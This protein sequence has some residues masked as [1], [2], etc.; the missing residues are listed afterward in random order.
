MNNS[1]RISWDL[2]YYI[3]YAVIGGFTLL[4]MV[5][6]SEIYRFL[7]PNIA[8]GFAILLVGLSLGRLNV[9]EL[10]GAKWYEELFRSN[11]V[12]SIF[13]SAA[14]ILLVLSTQESRLFDRIEI[15]FWF[16]N[17]A[18]LGI[19]TFPPSIYLNQRDGRVARI[20]EDMA[21]SQIIS[22]ELRPFPP[23]GNTH[24]NKVKG[25]TK[26]GIQFESTDLRDE[27][28]YLIYFLCLERLAGKDVRWLPR[29]QAI[30]TNLLIS[31][32][33][34]PDVNATIEFQWTKDDFQQKRTLVSRLKKKRNAPF[35]QKDGKFFTLQ[36][37]IS[38]QENIILPNV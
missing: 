24:K 3:L 4:E 20:G 33:K 16:K 11:F 32:Q 13:V 34:R 37:T 2:V 8:F 5:N 14:I 19:I 29:K 12:S 27:E 36:K 1:I 17:L 10:K 7:P 9:L 6:Y 38:G 31:F 35:I 18:I 25:T 21:N 15:W 26:S 23:E 28:Y 30:E 22:I